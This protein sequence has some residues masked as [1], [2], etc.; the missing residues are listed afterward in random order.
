M[1]ISKN[2]LLRYC[3][4]PWGSMSCWLVPYYTIH[5]DETVVSCSGHFSECFECLRTNEYEL[6]ISLW[7]LFAFWNLRRMCTTINYSLISSNKKSF[8][9]KFIINIGMNRQKKASEN[10]EKYFL[11]PIST[12]SPIF[13]WNILIRYNAL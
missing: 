8:I 3:G 6:D 5:Y 13:L 7:M 10:R 2:M 9:S 4:D 11:F 12:R 1:W